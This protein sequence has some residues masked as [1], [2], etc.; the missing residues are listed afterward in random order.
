MP[1]VTEEYRA[2]RR[3]EIADAAL[4]AFR[5]TGFQATSMADIIAESGLSAGAIY[6]HYPSKSALVVGVAS[7]IVGARLGDIEALAS[8]TPMT[9]PPGVVRVLVEA[10]RR[11]VGDPAVLLQLWGEAVTDPDIADL[12]VGTV[13][14]LAA[15]LRGYVSLWHQRT[16]GVPPDEADALGTEQVP[17]LLAAVQGYVIQSTVARDFDGEAYLAAVERYLPR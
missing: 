3:D 11:E 17:L 9:P 10:I 6:G 14:R 8:A 1:K 13:D 15:A 5:R 7:R 12:A 16:H 4:R 2:A